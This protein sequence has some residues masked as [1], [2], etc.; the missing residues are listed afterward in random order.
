MLLY[1][2]SVKLLIKGVYIKLTKFRRK[3]SRA[4]EVGNKIGKARQFLSNMGEYNRFAVEQCWQTLSS[5]ARQGVTTVSVYGANDIAEILYDLSF[6]LPVKIR[7]IYDECP[8]KRYCGPPV[9][10]LEAYRDHQE[11]LIIAAVIG[12][13][14]MIERLTRL[15]I[16]VENVLLIGQSQNG[17]LIP[18]E[19]A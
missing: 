13:E 4:G 11:L 3:F 16:S 9:L 1:K 2:T 6:E 17:L 10:P 18:G 5:L 14:E 15:G 12:A 19:L 8:N 7:A